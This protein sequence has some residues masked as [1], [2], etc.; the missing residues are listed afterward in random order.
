MVSDLYVLDLETFAWQ[1]IEFHPD[2]DV[3]AGRYFHSTDACAYT[4]IFF[5]LLDRRILL[6]KPFEITYLP[7]PF[8]SMPLRQF[9]RDLHVD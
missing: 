6:W 2:D 9:L 8:T 7:L 5:T 4:I 3:P 1:K